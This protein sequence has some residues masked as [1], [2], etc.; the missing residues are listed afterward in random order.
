MMNK[1]EDKIEAEQASMMWQKLCAIN[2]RLLLA[3]AVENKL[4]TYQIGYP[5][6]N[7]LKML[8][9]LNDETV[10]LN[11]V[12]SQLEEA[13]TRYFSQEI[14]LA[15]LDNQQKTLNISIPQNDTATLPVT[16][17]TTPIAPAL[18]TSAQAPVVSGSLHLSKPPVP[19]NPE[20]AAKPKDP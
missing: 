20:E 14:T 8:K 3:R 11:F 6:E 17:L 5:N 15:D 10:M 1:P 13:I 12:K 2:Q 4:Y 7:Q 9:S 16:N 19:P 18:S